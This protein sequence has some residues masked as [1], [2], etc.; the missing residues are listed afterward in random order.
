MTVKKPLSLVSITIAFLVLAITPVTSIAETAIYNAGFGAPYCSS[1][2][3][4]CD[5]GASLLGGRDTIQNGNEPISQIPLIPAWTELPALIWLMK[6]L[7]A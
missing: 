7:K 4:P 5:A 2:T 1:G 3:G 6:T